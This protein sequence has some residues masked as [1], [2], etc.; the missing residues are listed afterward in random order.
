MTDL[1]SAVPVA[2]TG[3]GLRTSV[4]ANALQTTTSV[5]A[6]LNR[7]REWPHLGLDL[8]A[9]SE[10][11]PSASAIEGMGDATWQEKAADLAT[12]AKGHPESRADGGHRPVRR[13]QVVEFA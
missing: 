11:L 2:I 6:R 10:G 8:G 12:P 7:F 9:D 1:P 5:R 4:G 13:G 3:V